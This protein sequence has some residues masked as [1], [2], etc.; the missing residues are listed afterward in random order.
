MSVGAV[1]SIALAVAARPDLAEPAGTT[2][3][4]LTGK[5]QEVHEAPRVAATPP[6][7]VSYGNHVDVYA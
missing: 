4:K 2:A 7:E 3:S 5:A 6:A 1:E